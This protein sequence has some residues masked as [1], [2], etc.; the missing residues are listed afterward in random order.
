[1]KYSSEEYDSEDQQEQ[2]RRSERR[3]VNAREVV[4]I[5]VLIMNLAGLVWGAA[6]MSS[7]VKQLEF[8][9]SKLSTVGDNLTIQMAQVREDYGARIRLL[10]FQVAELRSKGGH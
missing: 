9:V 6:T 1:M 5:L 7:S 10:E 8:S 3:N 2:I 4:S